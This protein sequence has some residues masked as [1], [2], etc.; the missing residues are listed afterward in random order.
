MLTEVLEQVWKRS[1]GKCEC[2]RQSH[3]HSYIRCNKRLTREM[4]DKPGAGGWKLY[5]HFAYGGNDIK[6]YA[7]YCRDCYQKII[8]S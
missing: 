2:A 5:Q 4:Q 1:G 3:N 6:A 7:V 8:K